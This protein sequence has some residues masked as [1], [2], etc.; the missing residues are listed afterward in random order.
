MPHPFQSTAD[1]SCACRPIGQTPLPRQHENLYAQQVEYKSSRVFDTACR[2]SG[3]EWVSRVLRP[4][5]HNIGYFGGG[6]SGRL[7]S[8]RHDAT[9]RVFVKSKL[10]NVV[11]VCVSSVTGDSQESPEFVRAKYF[12]RDLFLV[13]FSPSLCC[14]KLFQHF[15]PKKFHCNNKRGKTAKVQAIES[16]FNEHSTLKLNV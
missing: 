11:V 8:T 7:T 9:Q 12:F 5:C 4:T 13:I 3:S 16:R 15:M 10:W 14:F 2:A 6:V 1:K